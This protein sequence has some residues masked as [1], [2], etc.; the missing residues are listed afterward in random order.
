MQVQHKYKNTVQSN[1]LAHSKTA[2]FLQQIHMTAAS[3][4]TATEQQ[5]QKNLILGTVNAL[6]PASCAMLQALY[7]HSFAS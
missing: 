6:F 4:S 7:V 1:I 5:Q 3:P 2:T